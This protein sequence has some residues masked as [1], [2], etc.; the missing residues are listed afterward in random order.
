VKTLNLLLAMMLLAIAPP[1]SAQLE[2]PKLTDGVVRAAV[3]CDPATGIYRYEYRFFHGGA[4][5]LHVS[6]ISMDVKTDHSR[7]RMDGSTLPEGRSFIRGDSG[8]G[9]FVPSVSNQA[10]PGWTRGLSALLEAAFVIRF[11]A[12]RAEDHLSLNPSASRGFG[13]QPSEPTSG[14]SCP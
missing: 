6:S 8:Q 2:L 13:S 12:E 5:D 14:S 7:E 9:E 10:P 4:P 1:A 11:G 3:E